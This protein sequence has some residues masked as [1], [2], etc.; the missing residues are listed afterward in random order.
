M[1]EILENIWICILLFIF[2]VGA[3]FLY[4]LTL[5][6]GIVPYLIGGALVY[7]LIEKL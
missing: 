1:K 7:L 6:I 4:I 2:S 3:V 5:L